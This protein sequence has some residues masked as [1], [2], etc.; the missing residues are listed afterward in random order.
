[1]KLSV[2]IVN[3]N[4]RA[5]LEQCLRTV[6]QALQG[7]D[8]EVYVVDNQ[9]TDGSVE[10]VRSKFPDVKLIANTE[11]VGFSRANNQAIRASNADYAVLLN[12]DTVVGEDVF[13]KV[14]DFMDAHP[15]AGGLGV[16]MIDGR[17]NFL[18]ESKRGLPTPAVAF[19]KII[20]ITRLFP[21]SRIFGRYHLGHLAENETA[22][23][24]ILSGACMFLRK[25]TLD[26]VGLLDESFFM[27][28][29]DIDLS[30]RIT[31][32]GY[33]NWYF[34]EARI[35]HYKGES[36]K[37]SSVNYVFVFYNAMAIFAQKHFTRRRTNLLSLL[38]NGSIY[39]SAAGAIVARF[40]RRMLLPMVD[41]LIIFILLLT[42]YV[43]D[44]GSAPTLEILLTSATYTAIGLIC[45]ALFGGYDHPVRLGNVFKAFGACSIIALAIW[46]ITGTAYYK[47]MHFAYVLGILLAGLLIS[48][49]ALHALGIKPYSLRTLDRKR[50]LAIGTRDESKQALALLWQTHFGLGKQKIMNVEAALRKDAATSIRRKIRKHGIDEVV[51]CAKDLPW[52]RIIEL[53]EELRRSR[54]MFKIAQPAREFI[55]GP[56]SIESLS[57][58]FILPQYAINNAEGKRMKRI[59][60]VCIAL[61]T[62]T[63]LPI[64]LLL[65]KDRVGFL[66]NWWEIMRNRKS[67]VGYAPNGM[68][69]LRLPKLL[70]GVLDPLVAS[71]NRTEL[72]AIRSNITYAKDHTV[73]RDL[74]TVIEGFEQLGAS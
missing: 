49:V 34:P 59:T 63:L 57:D 64:T 27:Y 37:K 28:G 9:S 35:I 30:Y 74:R 44:K 39:L 12:P 65:V 25:K 58:L 47:N 29:E 43:I 23:I 8:G 73:L 15:K 7:V 20:G 10:M 53:M 4:V 13:R 56:N 48:R 32:S 70:P 22:P 11:N 67:W 40:L 26:E 19:F 17:G 51:F 69:S 55:I 68:S 24:E 54:V 60:D 14:I 62:V 36:T 18:P 52:G 5:Y 2:I 41:A 61:V 72:V 1:M 66:R 33:E 31:L 46:G 6:E 3:Y 38:I 71:A 42:P 21:R 16:K 50:V 45:A